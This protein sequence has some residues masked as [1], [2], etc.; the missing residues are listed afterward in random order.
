M[1]EAHIH[2]AATELK[3]TIVCFDDPK[4]CLLEYR[5][6]FVGGQKQIR[7]KR[8]EVL[9]AHEDVIWIHMAPGHFSAMLPTC[10]GAP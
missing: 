1:R 5:P 8:A 6:G 7:Q 9:R 4:K 10:G 3:K 2:A